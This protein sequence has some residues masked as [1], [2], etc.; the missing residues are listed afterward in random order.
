[1]LYIEPEVVENLQCSAMADILSIT[2]VAPKNGAVSYRVTVLKYVQAMG[3]NMVTTTKLNPPFV[4]EV[5]DLEVATPA[6]RELHTYQ[7]M[8]CHI[9]VC[10]I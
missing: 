6:L 2:W 5:T 10:L 4:R 9:C 3:T 1:M 8:V 7:V